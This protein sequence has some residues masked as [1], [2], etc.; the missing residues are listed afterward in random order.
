MYESLDEQ[1][2]KSSI[3][4]VETCDGSLK[5]RALNYMYERKWLCIQNE[6]RCTNSTVWHVLTF[7]NKESL[8]FL[9]KPYNKDRVLNTQ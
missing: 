5:Q 1:M 6:V 4:C 2:A 7:I 3:A 8:D 9:L